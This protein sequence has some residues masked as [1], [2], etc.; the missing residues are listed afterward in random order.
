MYLDYANIPLFE[1]KQIQFPEVPF[2]NYRP[3][4]GRLKQL[5]TEYGAFKNVLVIGYGGSVTSFMGIYQAM[6][7]DKNVVILNTID[8]DYIIQVQKGLPKEDTLVIAISKSGDT[9]TV[10]DSLMQFKGYAMIVISTK[11]TPLY[12]YGVSQKAHMIDHPPDIGGRFTGITEVAF[13]PAAIC[14]LDT[15]LVYNGALELYSEYKNDN[16]ALQA[17]QIFYHL[18]GRGYVD[19]FS[20]VYSHAL[21][22]FSYFMIQ[23][24]HESFGKNG[25]G[26]TYFMREAPESQHHT[27]QRFFGGRKNIAGFFVTLEHFANNLITQVPADAHSIKFKDGNLFTL[28][29]VPLSFAMHAE[30]LGTWEDAKIHG[31]PI[32]CLNVSVIN[33]KEIGSFIAFWQMFAV[34][35]AVLRNVNPFDQPEVENSKEISWMKRKEFKRTGK[36]Q[37]QP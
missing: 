12:E 18:E 20:P 11:G 34:Y 3:N 28:D 17:A 23:L 24:C 7:T 22:S 32:V 8:P 13:V 5:W 1:P 19:V 27:N 10:M 35:S 2:M 21:Y 25:L 9:L 4:F 31:L 29:N 16:I 26:Q 14:G 37:K 33:P 30:F 36:F 6:G 15:E